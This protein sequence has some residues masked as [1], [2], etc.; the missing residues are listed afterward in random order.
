MNIKKRPNHKVYIQALRRMSPEQRLLK[1]FELSQFSRDLF[2]HG[3]RK[4][5]PD[6][7]EAEIKKLYLERLNKCHNRNY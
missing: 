6:L 1:A 3:L 2:L 4:R 7:S 5:F